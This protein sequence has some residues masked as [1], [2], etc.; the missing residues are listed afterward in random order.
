MNSYRGKIINGL[1]VGQYTYLYTY[2][3]ISKY[4]RKIG[5]HLKKRYVI[6]YTFLLVFFYAVYFENI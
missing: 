4:K 5:L 3:Y 2:I 1:I 6:G